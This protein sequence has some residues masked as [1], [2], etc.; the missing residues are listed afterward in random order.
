[1]PLSRLVISDMIAVNALTGLI[2]V[3][4]MPARLSCRE[5]P[6][7]DPIHP[8]HRLVLSSGRQARV[9]DWLVQRQLV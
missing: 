4:F 5:S 9:V 8:A 1:M 6:L 2:T 3:V 7:L